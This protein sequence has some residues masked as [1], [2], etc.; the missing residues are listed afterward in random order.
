MK[1]ATKKKLN[2]ATEITE[3]LQSLGVQEPDVTQ[4]QFD[5]GGWA[6]ECGAQINGEDVELDVMHYHRV[7]DKARLILHGWHFDEVDAVHLGEVITRTLSGDAAIKH[8]RT[9]IGSS[10][11]V[12]EVSVGSEKYHASNESFSTETAAHWETRLLPPKAV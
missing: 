2:I 10:S 8:R 11:H 1:R 3:A 9:L 7:D 6:T 5:D 12:L 4:A